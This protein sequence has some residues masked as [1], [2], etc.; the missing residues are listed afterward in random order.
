MAFRKDTI[1]QQVKE[2]ASGFLEPEESIEVCAFAVRIPRG[3]MWIP[4]GGLLFRGHGFALT[5][6]RLLI[7][8]G[9]K[10]FQKP[11]KELAYVESR[12]AVSVQQFK[13]ASLFRVVL[14]GSYYPPGKLVLAPRGKQPIV[15]RFYRRWNDE[16]S[17]IAKSLTDDAPMTTS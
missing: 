7:T 11:R 14:A 12:G 15:F 9:S 3:A 8:K 4:K 16:F 10:T 13:L 1:V 17:E 2:A 5:N 6:R